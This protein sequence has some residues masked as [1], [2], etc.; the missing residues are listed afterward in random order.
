M[1]RLCWK[2]YPHAS[3]NHFVRRCFLLRLLM[4]I[5]SYSTQRVIS[6]KY[7]II[8]SLSL[9]KIIGPLGRLLSLRVAYVVRLIMSFVHHEFVVFRCLRAV[10]IKLRMTSLFTKSVLSNR[11]IFHGVLSMILL[12]LGLTV[13]TVDINSLTLLPIV[14]K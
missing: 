7:L 1:I 2:W 6:R 9:A 8:T 4:F 14:S 3:V 5:A 12:Q 10:Q 13:R 11:S